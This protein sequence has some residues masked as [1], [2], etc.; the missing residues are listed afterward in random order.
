MKYSL[1][2]E[3]WVSSFNKRFNL[4]K[5]MGRG[6]MYSKV[7]LLCQ[8]VPSLEMTFVLRKLFNISPGKGSIWNADESMVYRYDH[9]EKTW[10]Y[11]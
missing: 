5:S 7:G 4:K 6:T 1:Y 11:K 8:L 9:E 3:M 10:T 2:N